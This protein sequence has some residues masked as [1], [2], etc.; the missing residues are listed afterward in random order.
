MFFFLRFENRNIPS[1]YR[2][3]LII[4]LELINYKRCPHKFIIA[5][6]STLAKLAD[7]NIERKN[8]SWLSTLVWV[9][10]NPMPWILTYLL[11]IPRGAFLNNVQ[12]I[13]IQNYYGMHFVSLFNYS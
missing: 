6:G 1:K 10:V 13:N 11:M 2:I 8:K 7:N 9:N 5:Y 4:K 3:I 12:T